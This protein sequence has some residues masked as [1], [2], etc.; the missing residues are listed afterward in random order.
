[1]HALLVLMGSVT[2]AFAEA[3]VQVTASAEPEPFVEVTASVLDVSL[4]ACRG[5]V[6]ERFDPD[7]RVFLPISASP[8]AAMSPSTPVEAAALRFALDG[9]PQ[10]SQVIRAV[11][12]VGLG[13]RKNVP[14]ELAGCKQVVS[15]KGPNINLKRQGSR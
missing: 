10:G 6:W 15:V 5:V 7:A 8:C 13:C 1:M 3:P 9:D 14:F 4:P 2:A 11:V 12:V